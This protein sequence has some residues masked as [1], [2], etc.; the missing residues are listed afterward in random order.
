MLNRCVFSLDLKVA[1]EGLDYISLMNQPTKFQQNPTLRGWVIDDS[2]N[3]SGPFLGRR[4]CNE[5][6]LIIWEWTELHRIWTEC[7]AIIGS[8]ELLLD[9]RHSTQTVLGSK[10]EAKF[11]TF[12]P[13]CKTR[14]VIGEMSESAFQVQPRTNIL[15]AGRGVTACARIFS[16]KSNL[17]ALCHLGLDWKWKCIYYP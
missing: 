2:T 9:F 10:M 7:R 11:W 3:F 15:L 14:G 4:G 13:L 5:R 6:K 1:C 16:Q 8:P 17:G 12:S